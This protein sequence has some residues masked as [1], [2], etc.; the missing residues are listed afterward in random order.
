MA[1]LPFLCFV[2]LNDF[3]SAKH[4]TSS[5]KIYLHHLQLSMSYLFPLRLS[6][7]IAPGRQLMQWNSFAL[8]I[9]IRSWKKNNCTPHSINRKIAVDV[10][11]KSC[12]M[13]W[14]A[15]K[16]CQISPIYLSFLHK[17]VANNQSSPPHGKTWSPAMH[18]TKPS[19]SSTKPSR[20]SMTCYQLIVIQTHEVL[21]GDDWWEL[22]FFDLLWFWPEGRKLR[23]YT[24]CHII[25]NQHGKS[26]V[27][28]PKIWN[29]KI[30]WSG[31]LQADL[32]FQ[33]VLPEFST[34]TCHDRST[35]NGSSAGSWWQSSQT[36]QTY[37]NHQF[38]HWSMTI[39]VRLLSSLKN[40]DSFQTSL[41]LLWMTPP[42]SST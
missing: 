5:R 26:R 23:Y 3:K 29:R 7:Y 32:S 38:L 17:L 22:C 12:Q 14:N 36:S 37:P 31:D 28:N 1:Q 13:W 6:A 9:F 4:Q 34:P 11:V 8:D 20:S 40:L 24:S 19:R 10:I 41:Q 16:S 21:K 42:S 39:S 15:V 18:L 35:P 30:W 25:S 27:I 2:V 33:K